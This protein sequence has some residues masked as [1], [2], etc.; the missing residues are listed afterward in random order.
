VC[1]DQSTVLL[2]IKTETGGLADAAE[3][4]SPQADSAVNRPREDAGGPVIG[5]IVG[6]R[7]ALW[8]PRRDLGRRAGDFLGGGGGLA[9]PG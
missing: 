3:E 9:R 1:A 2:K 6:I 5:Y 4:A 7:I 8:S